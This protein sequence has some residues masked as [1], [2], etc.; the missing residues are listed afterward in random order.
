MAPEQFCFCGRSSYQPR[1]GAGYDPVEGIK[2]CGAVCGEMLG[3]GKHYCA[4]ECH[5]GLC[6]PCAQPEDQLCY[7]GKHTRVAAC[8][9]GRPLET[10]VSKAAADGSGVE[11]VRAVGLY[12][13]KETCRELLSCGIHR[14][15]QECH[16]YGDPALGHGKCPLDPQTVTTC[17]CGKSTAAE[18]GLQRVKCT[19]PVPSCKLRC[20]KQLGGCGHLCN[21]V[22]HPGP[23][24]PCREK[25]KTR[26]RCGSKSVS[27]ECHRTQSSSDERPTC[28]R[29]CSKKRACRRHQCALRCC[30]SSHE[31][32][33]GMV[34]P[35]ESVAPGVTDPHQC[36]LVC[37]RLLRC[38]AHHCTELC[39]RGQ[40]PPCQ[41]TSFDELSC[42]CGRT[43]IAPPIACGTTLPPCRYPCQRT[44][45]CG[46]FSL[47]S[48]ECHSDD[49]P[50]PPCAVLVTVRCMCG[51]KEMKSVP[52]H[53]SN[54]ASCGA[55]CNKLLPCGGHR[56]RRSCHRPDEPCLRDQACKQ[57]CG[58]PRKTC[59]HPCTL[60]CHTPAMCDGSEPCKATITVTCECGRLTAEDTCGST[61]NCPRNA[62]ASAKRLT[63]NDVC[64]LALRNRRLALAFGINNEA[65]TPLS[66]LVRAT[67]SDDMLQFTRAN[68]AWVRDNEGMIASF[69][70]DSRKQALRFTPMKRA[71]RA[72][73]HALAPYYGCTSRSMDREPLRSVSWDRT[74]HATIPSIPLST[75]IRYA[76]PPQI[77]CSERINKEDDDDW[78]DSSSHI[79]DAYGPG[80]NVAAERLRKRVD[81]I[82]I[83][84]LRHGL[85]CDELTDE[86]RK[87]IPH[88]APFTL[89]WKG[90]DLVEMYCKETESKNEHLV[91]W[92]LLLK[93]KLPHLG[94]AGCVVG[95]KYATALPSVSQSPSQRPRSGSTASNN[96]GVSLSE[97]IAPVI[98]PSVEHDSVPDDWESIN[99]QDDDDD[100]NDDNVHQN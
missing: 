71:L 100:D 70:G 95:K 90:E 63:C 13:C 31:D 93:S 74:T 7:C 97:N 96:N 86:I 43:R 16:P 92:E 48:H 27:V 54:A 52:C 50:C 20:Q 9:S 72:F 41:H 21:E 35:S 11:T 89:L 23:C 32:I 26:C 68:L 25:A 73:L 40:C 56:C 28:Q 3:C 81:Y 85:T 66:G 82:A 84:D 98:M 33:D 76:Q 39:H 91:K 12:R 10:Y 80:V 87:L 4:Q 64:M 19:D 2:P 79:F 60:P 58:K 65:D 37:N 46:H 51:D 83:S 14:C 99:V 45:A 5:S 94:V 29:V 57:L 6:Q 69:V 17:H 75:A 15:D 34:I 1:C 47:T 18:L 24:A 59:G 8:G 49:D 30:P 78:D 53:R 61:G 88:A 38:K 44:R 22:C 67:Y 55:I 77:I 42:A 36:T 62:S